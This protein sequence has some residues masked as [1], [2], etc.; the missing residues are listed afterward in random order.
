MEHYLRFLRVLLLLTLGVGN[1]RRRPRPVLRRRPPI[2]GGAGNIEARFFGGDLDLIRPASSRHPGNFL[3]SRRGVHAVHLDDLAAL[4]IDDRHADVRS[5]L[6]EDKLLEV[7]L[8]QNEG[9]DVDDVRRELADSSWPEAKSLGPGEYRDRRP[10]NLAAR[11]G[12]DNSPR[13]SGDQ[14]RKTGQE[15]R[16]EITHART[17]FPEGNDRGRSPADKLQLGSRVSILS[18]D[19]RFGGRATRRGYLGCG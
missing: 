2:N 13:G 18:E 4:R 12:S 9:V 15:G 19:A 8:L 11:R 3:G 5:L 7:V 1:R 6:I 16:P 10:W 14:K 17:P